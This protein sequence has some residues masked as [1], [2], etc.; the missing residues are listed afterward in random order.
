MKTKFFTKALLLYFILILGLTP[1][2]AAKEESAKE[3]ILKIVQQNDTL[4]N[5]ST[6]FNA[7]VTCMFMTLPVTGDAY[8]KK[9]DKAR[10]KFKN[11]PDLLKGQK[12]TFKAVI[13][14]GETLKPEQCTLSGKTKDKVGTEFYVIKVTPVTKKNLKETW[15]YVNT[16]TLKP[17][18]V[19]LKYEDKSFISIKNEFAP[20]M[21]YTLPQKQTA[22][23]SLPLFRGTAN[24]T[25]KNYKIN[26]GI[27]DSVFK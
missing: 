27:D 2:I 25:Y 18:Y 24:V 26:Q 19:E 12:E 6:E 22:S 11:I 21:K 1:H 7:K 15:L 3:I 23:F 4:E 5:F 10:I 17:D 8:F 20:D 13:P 14:S 16:R 9:P